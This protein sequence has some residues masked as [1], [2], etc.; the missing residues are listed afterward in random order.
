MNTHNKDHDHHLNGLAEMVLNGANLVIKAA[1]VAR[2][3]YLR[4]R[5]LRAT[6]T[7]LEGLPEDIRHDLGWPD[8]YERNDSPSIN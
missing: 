1:E 4:A 5:N 2:D 6:E 8:L 7:A 3:R